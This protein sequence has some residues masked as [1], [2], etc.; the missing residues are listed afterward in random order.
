MSNANIFD[1]NPGLDNFLNQIKPYLNFDNV[2]SVFE[3]GS[4]DACESIYFENIFKN[5]SIYAF[6]PNPEQYRICLDNCK[7]GETAR[8]TVEK[9]AL[10][11]KQGQLD[12]YLT[13]GNVGASSLLK[14]HF[15]PWTHDQRYMKLTVQTTTLDIFCRKYEVVPDVI[16]MDVQGNELNTLKGGDSI[17]NQVS[18][19]YTEAGV[20]PYYD[21]HTLKSDI[22]EYLKKFD[23][24]VVDDKLDW[25]HESNVIFVKK[26]LLNK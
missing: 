14:P 18:V 15:V 4:R 10:T 24:E 17:L 21:G 3:I 12:F 1:K 11:D 22:I 16:W 13:P 5:A 19:I 6:E 25:S 23:F 9:L 2:K 8:V 20:I 7:K 26:Q